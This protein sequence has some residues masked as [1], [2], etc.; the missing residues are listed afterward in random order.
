M[1]KLEIFI[2][3]III[4][5]LIGLLIY[6]FINDDTRTSDNVNVETTTKYILDSNY[7]LYN[8]GGN[9]YGFN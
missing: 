4:M 9:N 2:R 7:L 8:N 6:L 5:L 1:S 3:M